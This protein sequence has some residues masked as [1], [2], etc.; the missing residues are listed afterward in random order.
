MIIKLKILKKRCFRMKKSQVEIIGLMI[1]VVMISIIMLFSLYYIMSPRKQYISV[2]V[3]KDLSANMVGAILNTHS[4]CTKDTTLEKVL[5]DCARYPDQGGSLRFVCD[6]GRKSCEFAHD[7]IDMI[8]NDT[9]DVWKLPYEFKVE[10]PPYS[11]PELN[12]KSEG[13]EDVKVNRI[14]PYVQPLR[15]DTTS[16]GQ[17]MNIILCIGGECEI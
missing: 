3:S 11:I 14:S 13:L 5:M 12:F 6:D 17:T 4:Q 8:L 16:G 9:I 1:I 7:T 10:V 15:L 2:Y